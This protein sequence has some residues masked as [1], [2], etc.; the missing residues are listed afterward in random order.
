MIEEKKGKG[1]QHSKSTTPSPCPLFA[2]VQRFALDST[3][4]LRCPRERIHW[5]DLCLTG[6]WDGDQFSGLQAT[7][8]VARGGYVS[9]CLQYLHLVERYMPQEPA[10]EVDP[11][12]YH[13][14]YGCH[15]YCQ[16]DQTATARQHDITTDRHTAGAYAPSPRHDLRTG[17]ASSAPAPAPPQSTRA[18]ARHRTASA[19]PGAYAREN[20]NNQNN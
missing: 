8:R 11:S 6:P 1:Q 20:Q 2:T 19:S 14:C 18:S 4:S 12:T 9:A 17:T 13:C 16:P 15:D 10:P 7:L 3:S 5:P